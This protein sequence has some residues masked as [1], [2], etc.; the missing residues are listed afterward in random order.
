MVSRTR[1]VACC[2]FRTRFFVL[3]LRES[4]RQI[5]K[6]GIVSRGIG[7]KK[8]SKLLTSV[9]AI[10]A[11]A[12]A[13][14]SAPS[15]D[16]PQQGA[17][18]QSPVVDAAP[19]APDKPDELSIS[20]ATEADT[21][22]PDW[23]H[24][25]TWGIALKNI[26]EPLIDRR[27]DDSNEFVGVLATDWERTDDRTIRFTIR[28]GVTFHDG[29]EV[30]AE[31]VAVSINWLLNK[32]NGL[33]GLSYMG[34]QITAIVVDTFVVDVQTELPDPLLIAR[35]PHQMIFST[36]GMGEDFT[37]EVKENPIGTGPYTLLEY[38]RG[39]FMKLEF[40][41]D[42]WALDPSQN[43]D[44]DFYDASL[45]RPSARIATVLFRSEEQSRISTVQAGESVLAESLAPVTCMQL[46]GEFCIETPVNNT[47]FLR[48]DVIGGK[49][50]SDVRIR[51][52][53]ALAID[54]AGIAQ[55]LYGIGVAAS[56]MVIPT[57]VGHNASVAPFAYDPDRARALVSAA[58]ADGVDISEPILLSG[59]NT[60]PPAAADFVEVV[61]AQL[62]AVGFTVTIQL[63]DPA[64]WLENVFRVK[65]DP[66]VGRNM[67]MFLDHVN[68]LN[69][70]ELTSAL[71]TRCAA[72]SSMICDP[73]LDALEE[74]IRPLSG[75]ERQSAYAQFATRI[76]SEFLLIPLFHLGP[77]HGVSSEI[78]WSPRVDQN[79]YLKDIRWKQ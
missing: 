50:M 73:E 55:A 39:Q 41:E 8:Q 4:S 57:A 67:L 64:A 71:Y 42:W 74:S 7:M 17:A 35:I 47:V 23:A 20:A 10:T 21:L 28:Q 30:N 3:N 49:A 51:E 59:P 69:D 68:R 32:E 25:S 45:G 33:S 27:S 14:C 22:G 76:T 31:A 24:S 11:V 19:S 66:A 15:S 70:L 16:G 26:F 79:I 53:V 43:P 52:A 1:T 63:Q 56:Q 60:R 12:L 36:A 54:G 44:P 78:E 77:V 29:S 37:Q 6:S 40:N 72:A 48:P 46:F 58:A 2:V 18:P 13:A 34:S 75:A 9:L 38:Q 65:P 61:A 62:E 5:A